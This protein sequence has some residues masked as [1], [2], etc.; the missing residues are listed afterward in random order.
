MKMVEA[1]NNE[2][3]KILWVWRKLWSETNTRRTANQ[4]KTKIGR[5]LFK[6]INIAKKK[7]EKCEDKEGKKPMIQ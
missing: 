1:L 3:K 2:M 6:H 4:N 7:Q 5:K